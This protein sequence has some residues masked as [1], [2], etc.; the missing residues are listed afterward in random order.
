MWVEQGTG[1]GISQGPR[2]SLLIQTRMLF[3]PWAPASGQSCSLSPALLRL[4]HSVYCLCSHRL[5]GMTRRQAGAGGARGR[6]PGCRRC[7]GL[8][9]GMVA[10]E[11]LAH[12][13]KAVPITPLWVSRRQRESWKPQVPCPLLQ[14]SYAL[15]SPRG[16][17]APPSLHPTPS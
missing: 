6:C 14:P 7:G 17:A 16:K 15:L 9:P 8:S 10:A 13:G 11:E 5:P 2:L 4:W 1:L 12:V 3:L